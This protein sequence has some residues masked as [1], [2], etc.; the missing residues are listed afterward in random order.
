M[1]YWLTACLRFANAGILGLLYCFISYYENSE[2]FS[3]LNMCTSNQ[4][5]ELQRLKHLDGTETE[6]KNFVGFFS[7]WDSK[8]FWI[9]SSLLAGEWGCLI[10]LQRSLL[11]CHSTRAPKGWPENWRE[12]WNLLHCDHFIWNWSWLWRELRHQHNTPS[13][14][15]CHGCLLGPH[16]PRPTKPVA[17]LFC[18]AD[19]PLKFPLTFFQI[20]FL[21]HSS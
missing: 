11:P 13:Y 1:I 10:H 4:N 14:C 16:P 20:V 6:W 19:M 18:T 2:N 5:R 9:H 17:S 12:R 21:T 3:H 8:Q 7:P 15:C